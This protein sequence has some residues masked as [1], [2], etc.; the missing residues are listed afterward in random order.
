M[1]LKLK[2]ALNTFNKMKSNGQKDLIV[3]YLPIQKL[4]EKLRTD[5]VETHYNN[6]TIKNV[7]YPVETK[8]HDRQKEEY[9]AHFIVIK[10]LDATALVL[11]RVRLQFSLWK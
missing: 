9:L 1:I 3:S 5:Q 4:S 7:K 11:L 6:R 2:D 8:K 10:G